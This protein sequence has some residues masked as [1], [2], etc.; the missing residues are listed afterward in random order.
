M[1]ASILAVIER[2]GIKDEK[3]YCRIRR[4]VQDRD[5]PHQV[6]LLRADCHLQDGF[7]PRVLIP[8]QGRSSRPDGG[9]PM[10]TV[11]KSGPTPEFRHC[12]HRRRRNF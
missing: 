12:R 11:L 9:S 1:L 4:P 8:S 2:I 6:R 7:R 5:H 10:S 3:V